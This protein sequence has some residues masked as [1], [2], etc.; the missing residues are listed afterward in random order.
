MPHKLNQKM[1][2]SLVTEVMQE[3]RRYAVLPKLS[4][5]CLYVFEGDELVFYDGQRLLR[6]L[7]E[8]SYG[9]WSLR[10][11]ISDAVDNALFVA[12]MD[13]SKRSGDECMGAAEVNLSGVHPQFHG[14]KF[15]RLLYGFAL[16]TIHP[17]SLMADRGS[18]SPKARRVYRAMS[19]NPKIEKLPS[20]ESPYM[21]YFDDERDPITS[22]EDDDCSILG[23]DALN[24]AFRYEGTPENKALYKR[25][26][27]NHDAFVNMAIK[28]DLVH[29]ADHEELLNWLLK[30]GDKLFSIA[31]RTNFGT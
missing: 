12:Y 7:E 26:Q 3:Q 27:Q 4:D 24:Q 30:C 31:Y 11:M 17:D 15:G 2:Y 18:P 5:L 10:P 9:Y 29:G 6:W 8:E 25:M 28:D 16:M 23:D 14:L 20:D 21:G 13:I 22:P 1:L 19:K